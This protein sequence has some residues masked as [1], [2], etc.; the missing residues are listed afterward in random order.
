MKLDNRW[1][2]LG[3]M[4]LL[5]AGGLAASPPSV[6]DPNS[7]CED[8]CP[9]G[10][11]P[12]YVEP[13]LASGGN[14]VLGQDPELEPVIGE[15]DPCG[16]LPVCGPIHVAPVAQLRCAFDSEVVQCQAWP[17]T[18]DPGRPFSYR[19]TRTD[20]AGAGENE[21][22]STQDSETGGDWTRDFVASF[23]CSASK[24]PYVHVSLTVR[25]PYDLQ[26][27]TSQLVMCDS[28]PR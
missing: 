17:R 23:D 14:V 21:S 15:E 22:A 12:L 27:S 6:C 24:E 16:G 26:S 13:V 1:L 4:G 10:D 20:E 28:P 18:L 7:G 2:H 8:C 19:W 9:V 25:S 5:G 3:L 11:F